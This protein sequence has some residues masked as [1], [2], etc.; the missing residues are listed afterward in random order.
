MASMRAVRVHEYGGIDRLTLETVAVP[1]PSAREVLVRVHA[2]GVGPWDVLVREGK[3]DLGQS[4]PLV[5]GSDISGVV[6]S[7]GSDVAGLNVGDEVFGLTNEQFTG[8]YAEFALANAASIAPKPARLTHV[9]AASVPVIGVTAWQMLFEYA[10]VG[11]HTRVLVLGAAGNVGAYAV[12]LA[13]NAGAE[14]IAVAH[15]KDIDAVRALR[16]AEVVEAGR[17]LPSTNVVI[18]TVGGDLLAR[19]FDSLSP[20][21]VVVSAVEPPDPAKAEARGVRARYF[22]VQVTAARLGEISARIATEA[23]KIHVGEVLDL[24]QARQAH[25]MLAGRPHRAGKIVLRV[26]GR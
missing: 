1:S 8:G 23:V 9:E 14:V 26:A 7:V 15:A 4:L 25:E 19:S 11:P 3:S 22:I 5:I 16:P 20:G 12:Q 2:A 13:R 6:E 10:E 17:S 18:D 24:A 21:G